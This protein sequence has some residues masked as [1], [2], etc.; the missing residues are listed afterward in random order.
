MRIREDDMNETR[1]E[2]MRRLAKIQFGIDY[3]DI[4][5]I[6]AFMTDE[7]LQKHVEYYEGRQR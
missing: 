6:T 7:E 3:Q 2:L 5:T 4:T 1:R